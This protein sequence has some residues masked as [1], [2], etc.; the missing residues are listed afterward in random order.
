MAALVRAFRDLHRI[1]DAFRLEIRAGFESIWIIAFMVWC[2]GQAPRVIMKN[3]T[4][5]YEDSLQQSKID[6]WAFTDDENVEIKT[7]TRLDEP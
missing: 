1:G 6:L 3:G 7:T 2:I 5:I 4:I